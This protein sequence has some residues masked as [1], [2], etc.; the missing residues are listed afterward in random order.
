MTTTQ[1]NP[2]LEISQSITPKHI[3]EI[4]EKLNIPSTRLEHYG[5]Q[6]AKVPLDFIDLKKAEKSNLVLVTAITPTPAGEGKTTVSIG[7]SDALNKLNKRSTVVL[8]E[9]S[10]GPVFGM[11]GGATGGGYAQIIPMADINLH[12]NGDFSA[13]E[14]ANNLLSALIDNNIQS[15][16]RNVGLD[17]RTV[18]WKWVMDMNDRSL[19]HIITGLDG[20]SGG[21]LRESGFDITAASEIMAILCLARDIHDLKERIGNIYVGDKFDGEPVFAKDFNAHGAMTVLLKDALKP[22]L[23]QTLEGNP[24]IVHG[25]PF[26]NIAHGTNSL[27][28]TQTAMSLSEYVVTEAGF[29]ADLGAEKYFD[30]KCALGNLNPKCAVLIATIK[31][32][33]FHGGVKKADLTLPNKSAVELGLPNLKRH[34]ENLKKF[35]VPVVVTVNKFTSDEEEEIEIVK[36]LCDK[37]KVRFSVCESWEKGG[38]GAIDLAKDVIEE[39]ENVNNKIHQ[40]YSWDQSPKEK[41]ELVAKEVYRAYAVEFTQ[42]AKD[43]LVKIDKLGLNNLPVCIAKTQSSFSDNARLKGAPDGFVLHVRK[44]EIA[45]GAGFLIPLTG[46]IMRMPG[47]PEVPAAESIDINEKGEIVGLA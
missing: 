13:I 32:L 15:K 16:N 5:H 46:K 39:S 10:L 29:G 9:P 25:G 8:R 42:E 35:N 27:I 6:K 22:N 19:R 45:S 44:I 12:F 26:A 40:I 23:V 14:K 21:F 4:A 2:D 36:R 24:A 7:L 37:E 34:I 18:K 31:A 1:T 43:D 3:N 17:P 33:K 47:L 28:A 38:S 30:I 20:K 11:K 41:I